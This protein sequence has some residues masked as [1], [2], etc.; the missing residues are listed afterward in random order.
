MDAYG[1]ESLVQPQHALPG[2]SGP[3]VD[4]LWDRAEFVLASRGLAYDEIE[5]ARGAKGRAAALDFLGAIDCG[6]AIQAIRDERWFLAVVLAAKRIQNIVKDQPAHGL[7]VGALEL[8]AER[9]LFVASEELAGALES[10]LA[11][12]DF[13]AG[14]EAIGQLA[15]SLESFFSDVLVMDPDP[16]KRANRQA[17][18]QRIGGEIGKL[19]DLSRLVVDKSDYR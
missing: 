5:A 8:A 3:L 1:R 13:A 9:A 18:L 17:L 10:A 15:P 6:R 4:F 14:F 16:A 19:A 2:D 11:R 7:E 12:R